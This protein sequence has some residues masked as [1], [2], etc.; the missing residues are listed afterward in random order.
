MLQ[1]KSS[2]DYL[3]INN[4]SSNLNESNN[5]ITIHHENIHDTV[6]LVID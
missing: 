6:P 2:I 4:S 3:E 5:D 1:N